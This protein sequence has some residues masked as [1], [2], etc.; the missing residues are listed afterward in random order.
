MQS[1]WGEPGIRE[2]EAARELAAELAS[3]AGWLGL[4]RVEV[5][6]LGDLSPALAKAVPAVPIEDPA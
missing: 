4:D 2:A 5:V 6:G 3:M 1:T